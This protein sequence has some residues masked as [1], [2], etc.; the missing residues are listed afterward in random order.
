ME[1]WRP[2]APRRAQAPRMIPTCAGIILLLPAPRFK[3]RTGVEGN[4]KHVTSRVR[5]C[6]I[7]RGTHC[8][9]LE[10]RVTSQPMQR[11][12]LMAFL[13][14]SLAGVAQNAPAHSSRPAAR[15]K[16][17]HDFHAAGHHHLAQGP[18]HVSA[19]DDRLD[20]F[21]PGPRS[22]PVAGG[23][24]AGSQ[25]R[26]RQPD[27]RLPLA[28]PERGQEPRC[29]GPMR[30][31]ARAARA[32]ACSCAGSPASAKEISSPASPP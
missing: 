21:P 13:C 10:I 12:L 2:A 7:A 32:S 22:R 5:W 31:P 26:A 18:R 29:S 9:P 15:P 6:G 11:L 19:G 27:D 24:E 4:R 25:L 30:R 14:L 23:G 3:R 20:E 8:N 1:G 17:W 28:G 16:A